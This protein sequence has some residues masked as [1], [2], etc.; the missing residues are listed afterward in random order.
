MGTSVVTAIANDYI[1]IA[2]HVTFLA[3]TKD[4]TIDD[5][6]GYVDLNTANI[7]FGVEMTT[8]VTLAGTEQVTGHGM[9]RNLSQSARHTKGGCSTKVHR[10]GAPYISIFITA[11]NVGQYM[12]TG[13]V[14][15]SIAFYYAS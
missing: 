10:A 13:N 11:I 8:R 7:G 3:A 14:H 2:K 15:Y 6:S 12:A 5:T 4:G 1:C 9:S